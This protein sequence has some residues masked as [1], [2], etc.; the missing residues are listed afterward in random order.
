M[1]KSKTE[2]ILGLSKI[3][4]IGS[5][6]ILDLYDTIIKKTDNISIITNDLLLQYN[7]DLSPVWHDVEK[8]ITYATSNGISITTIAD[9]NFPT[10]SSLNVPKGDRPVILYFIGN[11]SLLQSP[12][13]N[14]AIIGTRTP[15]AIGTAACRIIT[16]IAV[17]NGFNTIS[18]LANGCDSLAHEETY[19]IGGKTIAVLPTPPYDTKINKDLARNIIVSGGLLISEY[20][21]PDK[22]KMEYSRNCS[23]RDKL[24]VMFGH[25]LVLVS[26]S[27][28]SGSAITVQ[29]AIKYKI[30]V[31]AIW[32]DINKPSE[33]YEL[34]DKLI[35]EHN[36]TK[37]AFKTDHID[38]SWLTAQNKKLSLF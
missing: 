10:I 15:D 34:N 25:K 30:P 4:G 18:G 37:I 5:A 29:N 27:T 14:I 32:P 19:N 6:K 28:K 21:Y 36:A 20:L 3:K 1:Y 33:C 31:F 38:K 16:N 22:S 9:K 23:R 7:I 17:K 26:G 12:D 24:V 2:I 8:D 13:K 11:I 35:R